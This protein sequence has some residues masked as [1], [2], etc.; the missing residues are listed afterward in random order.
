[1]DGVCITC[2]APEAEAPDLIEH[3]KSEYGHCYFKKHP[4]REDEVNR[5]I[6]A[7]AVSCIAGLRYT[8]ADENIL[9][10]L[11]E[12]GEQSQCDNVPIH[13]YKAVIRKKVEFSYT[14]TIQELQNILKTKI[15]KRDYYKILDFK[16]NEIDFF[17]FTLRWT[18]GLTGTIYKCNFKPNGQCEIEMSKE[19]MATLFQLEVIPRT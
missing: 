11:Y 17:Q 19:K 8:G 16:T 15:P 3:Q 12:I 9:M 7:V 4:E 1:M 10:K 13:N 5:A 14:G 18:D 2:G 6:N